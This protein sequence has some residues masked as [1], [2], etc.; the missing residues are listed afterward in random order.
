MLNK[1]RKIIYH[2]SF[3]SHRSDVANRLIVCT[4][5]TEWLLRSDRFLQFLAESLICCVYVQAVDTPGEENV[6]L[7]GQ[8]VLSHRG[9]GAIRHGA[10]VRRPEVLAFGWVM[11][12]L[13]V[14][15]LHRRPQNHASIV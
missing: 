6:E 2:V 15:V 7:I 14:A 12:D 8:K 3:R 10:F 13:A 11:N 5:W 9:L 4:E 1:Y